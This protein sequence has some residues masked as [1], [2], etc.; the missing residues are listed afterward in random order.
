[1]AAAE[2]RAGGGARQFG[3]WAGGPADVCLTDAA[4]LRLFCYDNEIN[5]KVAANSIRSDHGLGHEPRSAARNSGRISLPA[6]RK[7]RPINGGGTMIYTTPP[8]K[9]RVVIAAH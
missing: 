8:H 9:V 4:D 1:L 7:P 2:V 3:G 5:S 6:G